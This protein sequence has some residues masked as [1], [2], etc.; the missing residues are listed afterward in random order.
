MSGV[1]GTPWYVNHYFTNSD[2][3]AGAEGATAAVLAFW[4]A[5]DG[6]QANEVSG[7]VDSVVPVLS[8]VTGEISGLLDGGGGVW[9]GDSAASLLP[10]ASQGLIQWRTAVFVSGRELRG[11]TFIPGLSEDC[12]DADGTLAS[13]AITGFQAAATALIGAD[14]SFCIWSRTHGQAAIVTS[15]TF[16]DYF[17]VMR[18]RRD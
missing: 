5:I 14:E 13:G 15:A 3:T 1:A 18:S 4:D 16:P 11:R 8:P 9:Q 2:D 12:L 17:A 10:I 6:L 7:V